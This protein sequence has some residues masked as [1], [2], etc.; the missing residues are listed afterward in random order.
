LST[1]D[2]K[3]YIQ[4]D[5]DFYNYKKMLLEVRHLKQKYDAACN[6]LDAM[7]WQISYI[8]KLRVA[9]MEDAVL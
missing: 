2:I 7:G 9:M 3:V 1:T 4:S 5:D 8:V 6:A